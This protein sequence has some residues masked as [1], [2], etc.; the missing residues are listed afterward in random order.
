[1][2]LKAIL[3]TNIILFIFVGVLAI[4]QQRLGSTIENI[5]KRVTDLEV[6]N[7]QLARQQEKLET[8]S[9]TQTATLYKRHHSQPTHAPKQQ[10]VKSQLLDN[11]NSASNGDMKNLKAHLR[12]E[13]K[14][15]LHEEQNNAMENNRKHWESRIQDELQKSIA[16]FAEDYQLEEEVTEQLSSILEESFEKRRTFH[17]DLENDNISF[18]ELRQENRKLQDEM[19][20]KLSNILTE[21]QLNA[22]EDTFPM[23]PGRQRRRS[24]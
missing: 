19:D 9:S 15:V 16:D 23:G 13:V 20:S 1:M 2:I 21:E 24:R 4:Q 6:Q 3:G 12:E 18:Y 14:S 7:V 5:D 10:E 8:P 17:S 22:F 11:D